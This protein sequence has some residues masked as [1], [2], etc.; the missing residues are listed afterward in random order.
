MIETRR[1]FE[2][3]HVV[4]T[5]GNGF[6]GAN[7]S[8]NLINQGAIVYSFIRDSSDLWRLKDLEDQIH[9]LAIDLQDQAAVFKALHQ[10]KPDYLFHF[11]IPPHKDLT[12]PEALDNQIAITT[13][14]LTNLLEAVRD[15]PFLKGMVHACS[16]AIYQWS[17][18]AFILSESNPVGPT[19]RRG[20]LK[21]NERNIC[22]QYRH[23]HQIPVKLARIFRAYGPWENHE[24][25]IGKALY[26][27]RYDQAITLG[28]TTFKRDYIHV[29]DLV[30][31]MQQLALINAPDLVE[32]NF[33]SG[34]DFSAVEVVNMIEEILGTTIPRSHQTY[35]KNNFD[36]GRYV[37]DRSL[38]LSQLNWEPKISMRQGL[39]STIDWYKSYYQWQ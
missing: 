33:G 37:A 13:R 2:H 38:A 14:N 9:F 30:T 24:K 21:L 17:E 35:Q 36:Q 5:G 20:Q 3:Q 34:E 19:T 6:L 39:S 1:S 4:I 31:G 7:L 12:G 26:A 16:S 29:D 32:V 25:L 23:N 18:Q 28:S 22:L 8:R 10:I 11:A 15:K 27:A